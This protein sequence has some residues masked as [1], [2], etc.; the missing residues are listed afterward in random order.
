[1]MDILLI[2]AI[3][4]IPVYLFPSGSIQPSHLLL[5]FLCI[6]NI[7]KTLTVKANWIYPFLAFFIYSS[8][9]EVFYSLHNKDTKHATEALFLL[10]NMVVAFSV[11]S[12]TLNKAKTH[13][14]S[15]LIAACLICVAA[16]AYEYDKARSTALFNNP[17]QLGYFSVCATSM[18]YLLLREGMKKFIFFSIILATSLLS[19]LSLSKSAIITMIMIFAWALIFERYAKIRTRFLLFACAAASL[20]LLMKSGIFDDNRVISRL[21][22]TMNETDSSLAS[23][24]YFLITDQP[25]LKILFGLGQ[26]QI[27]SILGHE[28]HST[29]ASILNRY[30]VFGLLLFSL[31]ILQWV[32][33]L[34]KSY[35]TNGA[36]FIAAPPLLYGIM[37]NGIRFTF[38]W[39]LFAISLGFAARHIKDG[40]PPA[41]TEAQK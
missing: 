37:H 20:I 2:L 33:K 26:H 21:A 4:L 40:N 17:N 35:G 12:H 5:L 13:I 39:L 28:V 41:E 32:I 38:F 8:T 30:G 9:T 31:I 23:R 10:F 22:N 6:K 36:I 24:G 15:G 34:C 1:M 25:W 27:I 7:R 16:A 11:Y 18:A 29:F 14:A 3:T 19:A